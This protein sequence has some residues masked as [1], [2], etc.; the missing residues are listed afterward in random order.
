M[1][2]P[3]CRFESLGGFYPI[4]S[5][6]SLIAALPPDPVEAMAVFHQIMLVTLQQ[7]NGMKV[8]KR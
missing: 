6:E 3:G 5:D 7:T 2:A 1:Q 4:P 8:R